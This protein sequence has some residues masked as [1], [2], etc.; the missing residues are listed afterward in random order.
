[1]GFTLTDSRTNFVFA[2]HPQ[3]DGE[4]LYKALKDRGILVRHF[5]AP[6]INQYNRVTVGTRAEMDALLTAIREILE[7]MV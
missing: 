3:M 7:D 5:T 6:R 2:R 1:M 4:A